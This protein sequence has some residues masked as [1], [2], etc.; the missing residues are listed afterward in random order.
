MVA[1]REEFV[2]V[3]KVPNLIN[4]LSKGVLFEV[5]DKARYLLI[6]VVYIS[7]INVQARISV[8]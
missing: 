7:L 2:L 4:V 1:S 8:L 5:P 6:N 3:V